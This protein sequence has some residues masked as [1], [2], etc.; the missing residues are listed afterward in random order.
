[1]KALPDIRENMQDGMRAQ[2]ADANPIQVAGRLFG[3]LEYLADSGPAPLTEV[4]AALGLNKSTAHRV[5]RSLQYMGY[6]RQEPADGQ[7]ELTLRIA[8]LSGRLME[9]MD[10]I[11][12]VRPHLQRLMQATGETVHFVKREGAELVYIDKVEALTNRIRMV[13]RIGSRL[14]FYRSAVGKAIAAGMAP[15]EVRALWAGCPI[16]RA[17]PNTITDVDAFLCELD[18]VRR[19]GY[20]VDDEENEQGVRC[21]GASLAFA[22]DESPDGMARGTEYAF[23]I[24]A[25]VGRMDDTRIRALAEHLLR[26]KA[27]IDRELTT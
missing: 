17:T 2:A 8:G 4:A 15:D 21:V 11:A 6:V 23:S 20:A 16:E 12:L 22:P 25:P 27:E 14:P 3:A 19:R 13:S 26:T 24:S 18:M 5:L 7:Y 9:R 10:V 1:M